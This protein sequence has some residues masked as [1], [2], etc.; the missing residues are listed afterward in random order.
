MSESY[1]KWKDNAYFSNIL[2]V[3][4]FVRLGRGGGGRAPVLPSPP[5]PPGYASGYYDT[6]FGKNVN[7][8]LYP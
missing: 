2:S 4:I 5:P 6:S 1:Q 3:C 8:E 7:C